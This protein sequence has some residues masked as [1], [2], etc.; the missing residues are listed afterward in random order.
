MP[1]PRRVRRDE[2]APITVPT[3]E[4][5]EGPVRGSGGVHDVVAS[6]AQQ[7]AAAAQRAD[8]A[9]GAE[10]AR[11]AETVHEPR[12]VE[13]VEL[14]RPSLS[15]KERKGALVAGAISL[16]LVGVGLVMLAIPLGV[17]YLS[18]VIRTIA[19][20]VANA[21]GGASSAAATNSTLADVDP[22][23]LSQVTFALAMVGA[24]LLVA[25]LLVSWLVM[26]GAGVHRPLLVTGTAVPMAASLAVVLTASIGALGG[27]VFGTSETVGEILANA[28]IGMAISAVAALVV[29]VIVGAVVWLW[30]A[31]VFRATVVTGA[32]P[33]V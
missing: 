12:R 18:T 9:P 1:A 30:M 19:V 14:H 31:R 16:P 17:W 27:L 24:A 29:S 28:A 13:T 22:G 2:S 21:V 8:T 33:S 25:G 23:A 32:P 4:P 11:P 26:R 20:V 10:T 3:A 6:E 15:R 7:P 5:G